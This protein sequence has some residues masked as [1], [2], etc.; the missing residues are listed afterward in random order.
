M[1]Q[2]LGRSLPEPGPAS[3]FDFSLYRWGSDV[4]EMGW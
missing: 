2:K 4:E 3:G 1:N